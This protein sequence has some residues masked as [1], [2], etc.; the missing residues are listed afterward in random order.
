MVKALRI[1]LSGNIPQ[2][3]VTIYSHYLGGE[4]PAPD[5]FEDSQLVLTCK[6]GKFVVPDYNVDL[7]QLHNRRVHPPEDAYRVKRILL[8]GDLNF[9]DCYII[10]QKDYVKYGVPQIFREYEQLTFICKDGLFVSTD[11]KVQHIHLRER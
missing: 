1:T 11:F 9:Q 10:R 5:F 8:S 2:E 6:H 4:M 3:N 7:I